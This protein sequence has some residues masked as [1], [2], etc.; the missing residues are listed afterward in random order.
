MDGKGRSTSQ[1]HDQ[2]P[3]IARSLGRNWRHLSGLHLDD[4]EF[5]VPGNI[6]VLVSVDMFCRVVHVCQNRQQGPPGSPMAIKTCFGWVTSM[7]IRHNCRQHW[8]VVPCV[9]S[10]VASDKK[11]LKLS[12]TKNMTVRWFRSS[13][14]SLRSTKI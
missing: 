8:E 13:E 10:V 2:I 12:E 7:A 5:V 6:D 1:N 3:V 11:L 14:S 4:P 9:S